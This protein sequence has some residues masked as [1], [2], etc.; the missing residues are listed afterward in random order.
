MCQKLQDRNTKLPSE[1]LSPLRSLSVDVLIPTYNRSEMLIR[2]LDSLLR[3][4][5]PRELEV[6][7]TVIDNNSTDSTRETVQQY[8]ARHLGQI[9]YVF[10][11]KQGRS[12]ALNAG[13][14]ATSGDL[15]GMIDDDEEVCDSWFQSISAAF[16]DSTTDFIGGPYH[17]R[18]GAE[19]PHWLPPNYLGVIG[20]VNGGTQVR[21]FDPD[22]PGILMGG[23]AVIKRSILNAAGPYSTSLG[24]TDKRLLSCED[25]D[26]YRR[27]MAIGAVGFYIP[28][29]A[30]YH[31]IPPERLTKRY[32]RRWCFWRGV[33]LG[34]LDREHSSPVAYLAGAPRYLYGRAVRAALQIAR[35]LVGPA[36]DKSLT[37]SGE[38]AWWDLA[39][40]FY[41]KHFF[42]P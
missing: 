35:S 30:I 15:V 12:H 8:M 40:F 22:Y 20:W 16:R 19:R 14:A 39:G 37:F 36:P 27:L 34:I 18:W 6:R 7:I 17:P 38:L 5:I 3:A 29:L 10:E 25:E 28:S 2:T 33:S 23:N 1:P 32:F 26:M 24:R 41:G 42:R 4:A 11:R 31:Y 13:I 21:R 9:C